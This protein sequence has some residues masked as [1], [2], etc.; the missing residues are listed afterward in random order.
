[1]AQM[2]HGEQGKPREPLTSISSTATSQLRNWPVQ[3]H[4]VPVQA[5]YYENADLL[6]A[7]DCAPFAM[8]GFHGELMSGKTVLIGCPKLDDTSVYLD[9]LA[10]IFALNP[11][12]SIEIAFM[13]VPC[14]FGL[15]QL[16]RQA[17]AASRQE[18]PVRL[19]KLGIRGG[20][21]GTY[22]LPMSKKTA[23]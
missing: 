1:M 14:C 3:I 11:I 10:Q 6:I 16:V 15:V 13:E 22:E 4:L 2:L 18:I 5:P 23:S 7:A 8:A 17:L 19:S 20:F 12:K 9:K 21:E